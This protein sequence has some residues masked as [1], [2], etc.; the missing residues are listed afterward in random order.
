MR[1][2]LIARDDCIGLVEIH[3]VTEAA[4]SFIFEICRELYT[5]TP[6]I[7][8][9]LGKFGEMMHATWR[10]ELI[11]MFCNVTRQLQ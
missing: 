8:N 1:Q 9:V 11:D 7:A 6:W 4:E 10:S 5:H 2:G 3:E